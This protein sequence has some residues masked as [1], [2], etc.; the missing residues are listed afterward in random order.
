MLA[1]HL[2][3]ELERYLEGEIEGGRFASAD[4]AIAEALCLLRQRDQGGQS[5]KGPLSPDEVNRQLLDAGLLSRIPARPDPATYE[6]F[7]PIVVEGEPLSETIIR[8]RR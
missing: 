1:I 7:S 3:E 5:P 6:E 2:P 4:Q 8:E